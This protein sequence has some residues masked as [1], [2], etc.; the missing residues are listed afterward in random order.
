MKPGS[1]HTPETIERIRA[2]SL[3]RTI[4]P[5][6]IKRISVAAGRLS[7]RKERAGDPL[8]LADRRRM[9]NTHRLEVLKK[10]EPSMLP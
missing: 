4:N 9:L 8:K 1:R 2:K 10:D 6:T 5:E 3:Q 7:D